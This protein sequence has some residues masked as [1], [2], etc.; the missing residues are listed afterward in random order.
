[1]GITVIRKDGGSGGG[2]GGGA[3]NLVD[4]SNSYQATT[5]SSYFTFGSLTLTA[6]K[7][8]T[9]VFSFGFGTNSGAST[10]IDIKTTT[11]GSLTNTSS[12]ASWV[13]NDGALADGNIGFDSVQ[14]VNSLNATIS[15]TNGFATGRAYIDLSGEGSDIDFKIEGRVATGTLVIQRYNIT[16][17]EVTE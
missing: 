8:Y 5:S 1:M 12:V 7:K 11:D 13:A 6:G 3:T 16:A 4:W 14:I 17:I 9:V 15:T 10:A 2:G